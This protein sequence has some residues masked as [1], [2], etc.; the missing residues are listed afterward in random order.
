MNS[1]PE[2]VKGEGVV[3]VD[4]VIRQALFV[5]WGAADG[6]VLRGKLCVRREKGKIIG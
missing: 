1:V 6:V 2:L 3:D 5:V 4:C